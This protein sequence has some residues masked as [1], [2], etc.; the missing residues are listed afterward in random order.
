MIEDN[1]WELYFI[2]AALKLQTESEAERAKA[3][4]DGKTRRRYGKLRKGAR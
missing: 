1:P 3:M 2:A 4:K